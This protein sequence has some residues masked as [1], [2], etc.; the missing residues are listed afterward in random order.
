MTNG[1]DILLLLAGDEEITGVCC[2]EKALPISFDVETGTEGAPTGLACAG[3]ELMPGVFSEK[4]CGAILLS[5]EP[6]R[7]QN[8][9][10]RDTSNWQR[11]QRVIISGVAGGAMGRF[12]CPAFSDG[13][14]FCQFSS[15]NS[16]SGCVLCGS[17]G[18]FTGAGAGF[19]DEGSAARTLC[20]S[21]L[22]S[23]TV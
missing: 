12:D 7:G 8:C 9:A 19:V 15:A 10:V 5:D 16:R 21:A 6:Q 2:G 1:G 23:A 4:F 17:I 13:V 22:N 3:G 11:G 14:A 20:K 18:R